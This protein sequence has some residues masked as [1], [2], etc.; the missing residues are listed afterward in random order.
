MS[1]LWTCSVEANTHVSLAQR[2]G[3]ECYRYIKDTVTTITWKANTFGGHQLNT[4]GKAVISKGRVWSYWPRNSKHTRTNYKSCT[5]INLIQWVHT[6]NH[7]DTSFW[8]NITT[9]VF[10]GL[11]CITNV[12]YH[13][14]IDPSYKPVVYPLRK[15]PVI[16]QLK[17][18]EELIWMEK[19]DVIEKVKEPA[20][21]VNSMVML[22]KPN[23]K[24]WI[25]IDPHDLNEAI[26]REYYL[27]RTINKVIMFFQF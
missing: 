3:A 15:V 13:I 2:K 24:L 14:K 23:G 22:M 6:I 17:I 10:E 1:A 7:H 25:C 9:Y 11:G 19:L 20:D 8:T 27:K 21:W 26:K 4:C 18:Q 12:F 16:L 5:V